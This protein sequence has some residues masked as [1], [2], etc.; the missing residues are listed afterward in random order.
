MPSIR[1]PSGAT[2]AALRLTKCCRH[3]RFAKQ[4][5]ELPRQLT[6]KRSGDCC[7]RVPGAFVTF[8]AMK[9]K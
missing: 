1:N 3:C 4:I 9:S 7:V 8:H 2:I 5:Q 6:S